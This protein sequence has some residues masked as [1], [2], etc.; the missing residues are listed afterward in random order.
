MPLSCSVISQSRNVI[1]AFVA[2]L[3]YLKREI[4]EGEQG[5]PDHDVLSELTEAVNSN[6]GEL[7][8]TAHD[9]SKGQIHNS[10]FQC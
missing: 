10:S 2:L 6:I 7:L 3:E 1:M 5:T 4:G 8:Q 9:L